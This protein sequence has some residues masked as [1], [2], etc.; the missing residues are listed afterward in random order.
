MQNDVTK[1]TKLARKLLAV[2][3]LAI[4]V[5]LILFFAKLSQKEEFNLKINNSRLTV[6]IAK[7]SQ[8]QKKGLCCRDFLAADAGMLFVHNE[9]GIYPFWMKDT[10]I[11]LDMLWINSKKQI[12]HIEENVQ[13]SSFPESFKSEAPAQYI[14]ETNA[15]YVQAHSIK[16]GDSVRF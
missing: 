3:G 13:P 14:L 6:E 12:I 7:S 10:R 16:V 9:P 8:Q 15:G 11:A 1:K 2:A 4:V 5:V